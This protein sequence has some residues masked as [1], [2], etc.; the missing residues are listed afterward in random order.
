GDPVVNLDDTRY[1]PSASLRWQP[2]PSFYISTGWGRTIQYTQAI[3]AAAGPLGPQLHIGNVWILGDP[4]APAIQS[5]IATLGAEGWIGDS[6]LLTVNSYRR[7]ASG[8]A[9]P[10]PVPGPVHSLSR[11]ERV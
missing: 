1:S 11:R 9:D 5:E 2:L 10:D 7:R 8:I 4:L 3:G 6:W